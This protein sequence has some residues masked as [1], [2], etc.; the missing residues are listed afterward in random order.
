MV[1]GQ[2]SKDYKKVKGWAYRD[3]A[4]FNDLIEILIEATVRHLSHQISAG[5][6]VVKLFDSW[7]GVLSPVEF[8]KWVIDPTKISC[9]QLNLKHP[10]VKIIGFPKG[11]GIGYEEF[12]RSS[13]VDAVSL[14]TSVPPEWARANLQNVL[15]VQGNLDPI[16]LI[17]GGSAMLDQ[18]RQIRATLENG[19][20]VFNLGHGILPSTPVENV[21]ELSEFLRKPLK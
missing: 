2:S 15:P 5:A 4:G 11:V 1:E 19:P 7:A 9:T 21:I 18:A 14:D 16:V 13:G 10:G 8:K 17:E 3:P 6:D 20:F 12:V